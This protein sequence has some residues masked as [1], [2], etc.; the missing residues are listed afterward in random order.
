MVWSY[1][2]QLTAKWIATIIACPI[3]KHEYYMFISELHMSYV[4]CELRATRRQFYII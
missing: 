1:K 3:N 4:T 2:F